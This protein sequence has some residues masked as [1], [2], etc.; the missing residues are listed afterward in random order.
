MTCATTRRRWLIWKTT[1]PWRRPP[2]RCPPTAAAVDVRGS[3]SH[4]HDERDVFE[5]H[6]EHDNRRR[7]SRGGTEW[8][9]ERDRNEDDH[10]DSEGHSEKGGDRGHHSH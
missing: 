4:R 3:P 1:P 2:L 7:D 8:G 5:E 10:N 9:D 6:G